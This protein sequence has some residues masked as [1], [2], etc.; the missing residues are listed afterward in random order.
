MQ[1]DFG[2]TAS[3]SAVPTYLPTLTNANAIRTAPVRMMPTT[4]NANKQTHRNSQGNKRRAP[5]KAIVD[6]TVHA[7]RDRS[8]GQSIGA[9]VCT[10]ARRHVKSVP[11]PKA[12]PLPHTHAHTLARSHTHAHTQLKFAHTRVHTRTH[13]RTHAHASAALI[14]ALSHARF[15]VRTRRHGTRAHRADRPWQRRREGCGAGP[16]AGQS[17]MVFLFDIAL[18]TRPPA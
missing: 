6:C 11:L 2:P 1:R 16:S 15:C 4:K 18:G 3:C 5:Y 9:Q 12:R 7:T 8:S 13:A 10:A 17:S 14:P